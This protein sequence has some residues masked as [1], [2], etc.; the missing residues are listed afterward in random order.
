MTDDGLLLTIHRGFL[1]ILGTASVP[2]DLSF[3]DLGGTSLEARKLCVQLGRELD[4]SIPITAILNNPTVAGLAEWV[5]RQRTEPAAASHPGTAPMSAT[6]P[7]AEAAPKSRRGAG[8][9]E[10]HGLLL[11]EQTDMLIAHSLAPKRRSSVCALKWRL[12][13]P[14]DIGV[15]RSAL[16]DLEDRHP[17]LRARYAVNPVPHAQVQ[18]TGLDL[19]IAD[20]EEDIDQRLLAPLEIREGKVWR[21]VLVNGKVLGIAIHHIAFDGASEALL[22]R[23]LS[24]AYRQRAAGRAGWRAPGREAETRPAGQ[25]EIYRTWSQMRDTADIAGQLAFWRAELA[26]VVPLPLPAPEGTSDGGPI[27]TVDVPFDRAAVDQMTAT[28]SGARL[29]PLVALSAAFGTA[30]SQVTGEQDITLLVPRSLRSSQALAAS[31]GCLVDALCLRLR[32]PWDQGPYAVAPV[33]APA[34]DRALAAQDVS[35]REVAKQLPA[36]QRAALLSSPLLAWQDDDEPELSADWALDP[37]PV[38][39]DQPQRYEQLACEA[40]PDR[41]TGAIQVRLSCTARQVAPSFLDSLANSLRR[42]L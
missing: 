36:P 19:D 27:Y 8:L 18:S 13:A 32:A 21:A 12:A 35:F 15:L 2:V 6:R 37:V 17:A 22:A 26:D 5:T 16:H 14:V 28:A 23:D 4:M 9:D 41:R 7:V 31:I 34:I 20:D 33:I 39:V 11:P 3:F 38:R 1:G 42:C 30:L 10:E 40:R 24:I 29:S 25:Q